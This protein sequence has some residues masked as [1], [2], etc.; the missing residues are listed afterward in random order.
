[1]SDVLPAASLAMLRRRAEL[2][3]QVRQFFNSRDFL[4]VETPILS[5][6]A[7]V[8]R[9][10]DPIGVSLF[11]S[12]RQLMSGDRFWLQ[13]SPEFGMKRLLAAGAKAIFQITRAF[14][15]GE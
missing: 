2:L 13:T 15:G 3:A 9:H 12:P 5:H 14:R 1:M 11:H 6:D 7:V 4:E 8:D 10:I